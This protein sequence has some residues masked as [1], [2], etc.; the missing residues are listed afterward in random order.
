MRCSARGKQMPAGAYFC[1]YC[2]AVIRAA[3]APLPAL[4][5]SPRS[6]ALALA[7]TAA[8]LPITVGFW[9][10]A[11]PLARFTAGQALSVG[12]AVAALAGCS[13]AV[14]AAPIRWPLDAQPARCAPRQLAVIYGILAGL[15]VAVGAAGIGAVVQPAG[16]G[17]FDL[18]TMLAGATSGLVG[19]AFAVPPALLVGALTGETLGR[20]PGRTASAAPWAAALAWW[21]A[22]S[23]GGA[24]VGAFVALQANLALSASAV[25]GALLQSILQAIFFP[26]AAYLVRLAFVLVS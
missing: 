25:L 15:G 10:L 6:A 7:G 21:L 23:S 4:G 16:L 13:A 2:G 26:V 12:S 1:A 9:L 18:P 11:R 14:L 3:P 19:A 20:L 24:V 17:A 22:G 8:A 5:L